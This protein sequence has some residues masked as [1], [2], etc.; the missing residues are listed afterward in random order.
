MFSR[1]ITT[2]FGIL[3]VIGIGR[4]VA[5]SAADAC[6]LL[7]EARVSAVLGVSVGAGQ[8]IAA[9]NSLICGWSQAGST[10]PSSKR[11][12]VDILDA[13]GS[14]KPVDRFNRSK[15]PVEGITKTPVSGIGDDAFYVTTPGIGTALMVK[16]GSSVIQIR[17]YGFPVDEIKEKEK[18]LAQDALPKL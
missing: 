11:V 4:P 3:F 17:V 1:T 6:S 13:V 16:K 12:V 10:T 18:A 5:A 7:T 14:A 8:H 15:T 9:N 2:V